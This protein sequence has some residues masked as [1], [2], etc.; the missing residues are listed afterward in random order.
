LAV[1]GFVVAY[2]LGVGFLGL[3]PETLVL[4]VS[5][6]AAF[7]AVAL[8]GVWFVPSASSWLLAM[9][10]SALSTFLCAGLLPVHQRLGVPL[11][12]VPFNATILLICS[13]CGSAY[14][15]VIPK[16]WI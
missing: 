13:R 6:N 14:A 12:V 9:A 4:I 16:P 11:M 3:A 15:T 5:Y 10:A 7:A 8:G 2:A 1:A